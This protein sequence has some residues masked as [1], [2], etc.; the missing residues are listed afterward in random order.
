MTTNINPRKRRRPDHDYEVV[1]VLTK[2]IKE[3]TS[4]E[5]QAEIHDRRPHFFGKGGRVLKD[6]CAEFPSLYVLIHV[7]GDVDH[8]PDRPEPV[9]DSAELI[10][11]GALTPRLQI[12]LLVKGKN[13]TPRWL[14]KA[15]EQARAAS[16]R[17]AHFLAVNPVP[18]CSDM[19]RPMPVSWHGPLIDWLV[20]DQDLTVVNRDRVTVQV[21]WAGSA[22][23]GRPLEAFKP[24]RVE[25]YPVNNGSDDLEQAMAM[26]SLDHGND[27]PD[28]RAVQFNFDGVKPGAVQITRI[29]ALHLDSTAEGAPNASYQLHHVGLPPMD[30]NVDDPDLIATAHSIL[31]VFNRHAEIIVAKSGLLVNSLVVGKDSSEPHESVPESVPVVD[32][33]RLGYHDLVVAAVQAERD[34]TCPADERTARI[35]NVK[36]ALRQFEDVQ[37]AMARFLPSQQ[38]VEHV[39]RWATLPLEARGSFTRL[40]SFF[41]S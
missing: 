32:T 12:T 19:S 8:R 7:E 18:F 4:P 25:Y 34:P 37:V 31:A 14:A 22:Y 21:V 6:L 29:T 16:A 28:S 26:L 1:P 2:A 35:A 3:D 38:A 36:T 13:W 33:K 5:H 11:Y 10:D 23:L 27:E 24:V 41:V 9:D 40:P 20:Q 15:Q 39:T 30:E 17:I